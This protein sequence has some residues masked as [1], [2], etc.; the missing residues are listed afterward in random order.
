MLSAVFQQQL[1]EAVLFVENKLSFEI[2]LGFFYGLDEFL[3]LFLVGKIG[4]LFEF[5]FGEQ[6]YQLGLAQ[7]TAELCGNLI[8]FLNIQEELSEVG[9]VERFAALCFYFVL[10]GGALHQLASKFPL[11]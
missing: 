6:F 10:I 1:V 4:F 8:V 5:A 11:V 7:A 9:A 2:Q 3:E